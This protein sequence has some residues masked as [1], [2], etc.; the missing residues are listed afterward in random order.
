MLNGRTRTAT[1]TLTVSAIKIEIQ[2]K[3]KDIKKYLVSFCQIENF[4]RYYLKI[5]LNTRK[6][7][8]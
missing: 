6:N 7:D 8:D 5:K 1:L 3:F 2:F 4:I